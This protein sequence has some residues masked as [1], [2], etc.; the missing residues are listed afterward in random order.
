MLN[1]KSIIYNSQNTTHILYS[2]FFNLK[3]VYTH[4][5]IVLNALLG[6]LRLIPKFN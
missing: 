5:P 6:I 4:P 1:V 2:F 3:N